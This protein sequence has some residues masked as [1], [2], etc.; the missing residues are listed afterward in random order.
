[1]ALYQVYTH[2]HS[3]KRKGNLKG[4]KEVEEATKGYIIIGNADGDGY[5]HYA[6]RKAAKSKSNSLNTGMLWPLELQPINFIFI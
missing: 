5:L 6:T 4:K 3:P 2:R 1:M